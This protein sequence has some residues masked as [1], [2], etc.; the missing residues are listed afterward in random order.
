MST[1]GYYDMSDG[2]GDAAQVN[3][4]TA[5]GHTAVN[6]TEPDAAQLAGL[7]TLYVQNPSNSGFGAEYMANMGDISSAVSDGMNL[8]IFDRAVTN[9]DTI[10][11]GGA[12]ITAVRDFADGSN[13]D[14]AAGAPTAFTNGVSGN[15][16]DS[17]LDG[18]NYSNHGYVELSSLPAGATPLLT[19]G[20]PSHVVAFTYPFGDGNV[21][22]STMPLDYYT[23]ANHS[24]ITQ[25]EIDIFFGN[26][27]DILCFASGTLIETETGPRP[28]ERLNPGD[29]VKT[30]DGT[31]QPL[32]WAYRSAQS[33]RTLSRNPKLRPVRIMA[34]ALGPGLPRRDLLVSRQHRIVVRSRIVE[35]MFGAPEV[36]VAA[37]RLTALPG[38]FVDDRVEQVDYV[39]LLFERH[40]IVVA[41]GVAAESLLTGPEA[42]E[43]LPAPARAE[44]LTIFP[45]LAEAPSQRRTARPIPPRMKQKKL[46][47]RHGKNARPLISAP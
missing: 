38:I 6:V 15:L 17:T 8:I 41:E 30:A 19:T 24:A 44:L 26:L 39:H 5:N 4:I 45:E 28:V 37:I 11:P 20:D 12:T 36:L 3:E 14:I 42:L 33:A 7:D 31:A 13:V 23:G 21:F 16:T 47:E 18:G 35:R 1:I 34:G 2:Q 46:L 43:A 40:E 29:R 32:V 22:Y 27:N 9:A 25:S 10:L